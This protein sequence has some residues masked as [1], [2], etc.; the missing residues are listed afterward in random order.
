MESRARALRVGPRPKGLGDASP[1]PRAAARGGEGGRGGGVR[2]NLQ[3]GR[4]IYNQGGQFATEHPEEDNLQ[5]QIA[6]VLEWKH[7]FTT[8]EL[9]PTSLGC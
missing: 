4:T 2:D 9:Q 1:R 6:T 8:T 5:L 3:P 7:Q